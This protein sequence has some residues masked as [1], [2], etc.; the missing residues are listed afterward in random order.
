MSN[1]R[2]GRP[3]SDGKTTVIYS[4]IDRETVADLDAIRERMRPKPSRAQMIDAAVAEYVERH[5]GK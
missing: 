4:R 5:K 1:P 3:K 2:V